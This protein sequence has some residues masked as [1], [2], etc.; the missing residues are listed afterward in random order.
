MKTPKSIQLRI[1]DHPDKLITKA[2]ETAEKHGLQFS[3]DTEGGLIKGFGIE[4]DYKLRADIL[5][6]TVFRKPILLSWTKVE[7]HV[8]TLVSLN[9]NSII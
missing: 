8:R 9:S 2:K 5:T 3:G 1:I 6:V 7:Q 4:A